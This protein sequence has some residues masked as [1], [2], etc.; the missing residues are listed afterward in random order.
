MAQDMKISQMAELETVTGSEEIP[1][2]LNGENYK[3][4]S[5]RLK[6]APG[7]PGTP[8]ANGKTPVLEA[9]TVTTLEP[10]QDATASVTANGQDEQ[11]NPKYKI[12]L[13]IP[14]GEPGSSGSVGRYFLGTWTDGEL[15]PDVAE[16][17]GD[18]GLADEWHMYL[19]DTTDNAGE[20]TTPVGR[21]M[22][23]NYLRFADGSFAPTVGITAEQKAQCDV[24]L[25]LNAEHTEKYCDAGAFDAEAFYNQY[26][27]A[28]KLYTADGSEVTH[29][30]RP[31]ETTETKYT[32]GLGRGDKIFLIDQARGVSGKTWRGISSTPKP[33]DGIDVTAY[34][35]APT[36]ISPSPVCTVGG[37]T[38]AFFYLYEGETNCQSANGQGNICTMFRNGRTY[39][40]V[41][42]MQQ[43]NNMNYARANNADTEKPYPF[44]EGGYHALNTFI[45]AMEVLYGTKYLHKDTLFGSG[46]SSNDSCNDEET[47]KLHGGVRYKKTAEADGWKYSTWGGQGDIYYNAEGGRTNFNAMINQEYP[48]QQCMESQMAASFAVET[49]VAEGEEFTFYGGTY[50]YGNPAGIFGLNDGEMNTRV[51][52]KM[53]Q[54][55]TAYDAEGVETSWDVEVILRMSLIKGMNLSGDIFAYWGGGYEQVGT[56]KYLQETQRTGNPVSLYLQPDQ[57][58]WLRETLISKTDLGTFDFESSYKKIGETENIDDGYVLKRAPYSAFKTEKGGSVST[59][60]CAYVTDSNYWGNVIDS[61]FRIAVRLRG[62]ANYGYCSARYMHAYYAASN[63]YRIAGS[64]QAL[65]GAAPT[66][67]E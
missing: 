2:A 28:Q 18:P 9:G 32:M 45:T 15:D 24:E 65:I 40:R 39:P 29:I 61:R 42:D 60:E 64:A 62:Y 49:G 47:W 54:T 14:Q 1:V 57:K 35:L 46:I 5:E 22:R 23:N 6:G 13:G 55:F 43:V 17:T 10:G 51:Y 66:Q 63:A 26:G 33:Y 44:A 8:G 37:K 53:A 36:A 30:L 16:V 67:S 11:G 58:Q 3:I 38:R 21:L 27:M 31:W 19:I 41:N 52:K 20:T 12:D 48:K 56:C 7:A 4:K 25:Y 50:W 34:P 59:G